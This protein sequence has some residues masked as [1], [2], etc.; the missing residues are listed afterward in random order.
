MGRRAG[1]DNQP[2]PQPARSRPQRP[3]TLLTV[4]SRG[5]TGL[6]D[7]PSAGPA[8]RARAADVVTVR[9]GEDQ[10]ADRTVGRQ[11][12]AAERGLDPGPGGSGQM[13]RS[14]WR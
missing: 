13:A 3:V 1:A 6:S 12:K 8:Q 5:E 9:V 7:H 11:V 10:M 2:E 4:Q 14:Q